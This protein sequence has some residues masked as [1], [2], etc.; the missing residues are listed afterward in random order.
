MTQL[1]A[2]TRI[3]ES[4]NDYRMA[5]IFLG[6]WLE[7]INY[8]TE[9]AEVRGWLHPT[10]AEWYEH[11]QMLHIARKRS[12]YSDDH[13]KYLFENGYT[14]AVHEKAVE[15]IRSK[16]GL[17]FVEHFDFSDTDLR[18]IELV[19]DMVRGMNYIWGWGVENKLYPSK[20]EFMAT[21]K[22]LVK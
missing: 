4:F 12:F 8:H 3:V 11:L 18:N 6:D 5:I 9:A 15:K 22:K 10:Q 20:E 14:S 13:Y 17:A 1:E 2:L 7:D 19:E 16:D 21:L